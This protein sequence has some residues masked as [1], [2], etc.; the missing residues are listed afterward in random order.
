M[1]DAFY[2]LILSKVMKREISSETAY[3]LIQGYKNSK[4][5]TSESEVQDIAIVGIACR[6]PEADDKNQY[7]ENIRLGKD[8]VRDFPMSRRQ[9][10]EPF[11]SVDGEKNYFEGGYLDEVSGFDFK[12]FNIKEEEAIYMDPQQRILLETSY[13]VFEDAGYK[14]EDIEKSNTG[15]FIGNCGSDYAKFINKAVP[16]AVIGNAPTF[17]SGRISYTFDLRGPSLMVNTACSSSLVAVH[18]AC[19]SLN[20]KECDLALAGGIT[21]FLTP[22]NIPN[23]I[24]NIVG[25]TSDEQKCKAFDELAQGIAKGE[26]C[27]V[28]ILKRLDDAI[29]DKDHIYAVIKSSVMN[30]DGHS[31]GLTSP[32]PLA[33]ADLIKE[34]WIKADINPETIKYFEAHGTGTKLGDPIEINGLNMAFRSFTNRKQFCAIGSSK[35]NIGHLADGGAG[36]A[37]LIKAV[38]A[39]YDKEL[40]PTI[41]FNIPNKLINFIDGPVYVND[42]VKPWDQQETLRR[43]GLS[44]FGLSGTN[45][46]VVLEEVINEKQSLSIDGS[47]Q[48]ITL[49]AKSKVSLIKII[50][51]YIKYLGSNTKYR[52]EDICFTANTC[53]NVYE[54]KIAI[55]FEDKDDLLNKLCYLVENSLEYD[56]DTLNIFDS[57]NNYNRD[58][59][60][61]LKFEENILLNFALD[62]ISNKRVKWDKVYSKSECVKVS[63]PTYGFDHKRCWVNESIKVTVEKSE[64]KLSLVKKSVNK[65]INKCIKL[66]RSHIEKDITEICKEILALDQIGIDDDLFDLGMQSLKVISLTSKIYELFNAEISISE[67]FENPTIELI[68]KNIINSNSKEF[69]QIEPVEKKEW[70]Q[71]SSAQKRLY[72]IDS[73]QDIGTSYNVYGAIRM[74]GNFEKEK[75]EE[76]INT[77]IKRHEAF[78]TYFKLINDEPVQMIDEDLKFNVIYEN[79]VNNV[80][81][82]VNRFVKKFDLSKTP[83]I[84][85]GVAEINSTNHILVFDMHHIISDGTSMGILIKEFID[86]YEGKELKELRIQYKDFAHW[87]NSMFNEEKIKHQ[88]KYW[89]ERFSGQIPTLN[90]DTDYQ[91]PIVKSFK[92]DKV[93][94]S[95]GKELTKKLNKV[96]SD[97]Q[98]TLYMVFLTVINVLL[99]KYSGDEDIIIGSP[100]AG[101]QHVD[102]EHVMG[103]FVNTLAMRNFPRGDKKFSEFLNEVRINSLEAL[104]NQEYQFEELVVKL[105]LDRDLSKNPLFNILFAYQNMH[106]PKVEIENMKFEPYDIENQTSLFDI[107]FEGREVDEEVFFIWE[108][109][110]DIFKKSSIERMKD[111]F[112]KTLNIVNEDLDIKICD[113]KFREEKIKDKNILGDISFEF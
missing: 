4:K 64:D 30:Q 62:Y 63:I 28:L 52:L 101:R 82:F 110:T 74:I 33:Q 83:L 3:S 7:W 58:I 17:M 51:K 104:E 106:I 111:D 71:L 55:I 46:H 91:R 59:D 65:N 112:L 80:E 1:K 12:F 9:E 69:K 15:V 50:N 84:N 24:W 66:P 68:A 100:V 27:G 107:R 23:D 18:M 54:Y 75:F 32:N 22:L 98:T 57:F 47:L 109:S 87:Q 34:A 108:Y 43:A 16:D 20:R 49:S 113:I 25:I 72:I 102:L 88:E 10:I 93:K 26:G 41:H 5:D 78:R 79:E 73:F 36:V 61:R 70:Y 8:S 76:V 2:E 67:I 86:L 60:A 37:G 14:Y 45:C 19:E 89:L 85:V 97:T 90:L 11:I 96:A 39:L 94:F 81:E 35:T 13:E 92:G 6:Y 105:N 53:R 40:P 103:M 42:I 44:S 38:I 95:L 31:N 77:L 21:L 48:I 99:N 29:R 56:D